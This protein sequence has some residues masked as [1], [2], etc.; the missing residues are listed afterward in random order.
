MGCLLFEDAAFSRQI[1]SLLR[2]LY[3]HSIEEIGSVDLTIEKIGDIDLGH[4]L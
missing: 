3:Q 2:G 1:Y 4:T